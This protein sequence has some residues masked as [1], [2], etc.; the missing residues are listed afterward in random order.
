MAILVG[1]AT[2][3]KLLGDI[4]DAVNKGEAPP[5]SVDT[6]GDFYVVGSS[7]SDRAWL[8]P[9]VQESQLALF[10]LAPRGVTLSRRTYAAVH[11]NFIDMLLN[12]FDSR[13]AQVTATALPSR[14]DVIR[15]ST[16]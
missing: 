3:H 16:T 7:E 11:A 4:R 5:W 13:F 15:G 1:T 2:P 6:D 10:I 12:H 14:G 8:R 9:K